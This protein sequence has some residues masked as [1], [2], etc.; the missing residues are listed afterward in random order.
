MYIDFA[1][2][3]PRRR[4]LLEGLQMY[5]VAQY[6]KSYL[7]MA[8]VATLKVCLRGRFLKQNPVPEPA[9]PGLSSAVKGLK[10][11]STSYAN[12]LA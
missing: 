3:V 12:E 5:S 1:K 7:H 4:I 6:I 11:F 10:H 8:E 9:K 2:Q